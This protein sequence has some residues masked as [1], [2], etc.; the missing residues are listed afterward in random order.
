MKNLK[1]KK[2]VLAL[3]VLFALAVSGSTYAYWASEVNGNNQ[4]VDN[5][6]NIGTGEEITIDITVSDPETFSDK[7]VPTTVTPKSGETNSITVTYTVTW[8]DDALLDG[9]VDAEVLANV[10]NIKVANVENP[11]GLISVEASESNP[12]TIGLGETVTFTFTVEM[13]EPTNIEQYNAVANKEI[14]FNITFEV[15]P[16]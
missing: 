6:V 13:A 7:L 4:T 3:L 8:E 1:G 12:S 11:F 16:Q 5:G 14:T 10:Q 2:L 9:V 15:N